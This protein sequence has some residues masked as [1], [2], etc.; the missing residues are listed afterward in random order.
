M[1]EPKDIVKALRDPDYI[2]AMHEELNNFKRNE[3]LEQDGS[4]ATSKIKMG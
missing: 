4:F 3:V 2:N 1:K